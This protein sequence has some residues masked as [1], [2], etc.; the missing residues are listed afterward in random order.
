MFSFLKKC[1]KHVKRS[2][3]KFH[4]SLCR[5]IKVAAPVSKSYAKFAHKLS[6]FC[7]LLYRVCIIPLIFQKFTAKCEFANNARKNFRDSLAVRNFCLQ[8]FFTDLLIYT[9]NV[10]NKKA[11]KNITV[12]KLLRQFI[13]FFFANF[14]LF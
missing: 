4:V 9:V 10:V 3:R 2:K 14:I 13:Y 1:Q 6:N 11:K 5:G 8:L 12:K 7:V